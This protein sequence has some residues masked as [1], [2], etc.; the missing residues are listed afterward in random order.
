VN[1]QKYT[2]DLTDFGP[3]RK[4]SDMNQA[5]ADVAEYK[6]GLPTTVYYDPSNPAIA[7]LQPGVHQVRGAV[8]VAAAVGTLIGAIACIVNLRRWLAG[9]RDAN[10]D[11][12]SQFGQPA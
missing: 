2:S 11:W 1:G 7:V 6:P 3:G 10:K 9:R 5:L 4:R 12:P 8:L